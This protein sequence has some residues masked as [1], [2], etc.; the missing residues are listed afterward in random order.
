MMATEATFT[1]PPGEFPLGTVFERLPG[2]T[3]KLERVVPGQ[4]V[5]IPYFW[6]RGVETNDIEEAFEAHPGVQTLRLVDSV[7]DEYLFRVEWAPMYE[8]ILSALAEAEIP[9]IDAVGTAENWTFEVRGDT[10]SDLAT[11]HQRCRERDIPIR[12][13]EVHALLPV[14]TAADAAITEAQEE[15]L[16]LAYDRGYFDSPREV[17]LDELADELGISQ[18]AVASRIRRG[19]RGVLGAALSET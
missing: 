10:R 9:L 12:L 8:G 2:A 17:T 15:A 3:V 1:V 6:V 7:E 16:V 13:T 4:E 19:L 14:E 5:V 18:Q 11:F